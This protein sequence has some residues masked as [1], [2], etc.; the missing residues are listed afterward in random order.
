MAGYATINKQVIFSQCPSDVWRVFCVSMF[1]ANRRATADH[2]EIPLEKHCMW[3]L[4]LSRVNIVHMLMETWKINIVW[5]Q[6]K[7]AVKKM[8]VIFSFKELRPIPHVKAHIFSVGIGPVADL[9][10]LPTSAKCVCKW[11]WNIVPPADIDFIQKH[12]NRASHNQAVVRSQKRKHSNRS[13][14]RLTL[15]K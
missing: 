5:E 4:P 8:M 3:N 15:S 1:K 6:E 7:R 9:G 14:S 11:S 12:Q 10:L 13:H 2:D